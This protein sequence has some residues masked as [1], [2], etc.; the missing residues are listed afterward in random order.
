MRRI[1]ENCKEQGDHQPTQLVEAGFDK[2]EAATFRPFKGKGCDKCGGSGY[3]GRVGLFE[4]MEVGDRLR[5][6]IVTNAPS[7]ELRKTAMAEGMLTLRQSGLNKVRQGLTT[8][9]EVVRETM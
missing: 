4:V 2:D 6:L 7:T 3:K 9:D 8:L 5:D 1:C